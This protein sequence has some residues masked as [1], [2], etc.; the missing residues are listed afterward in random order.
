MISQEQNE[1]MTRVGPGT[2]AGNLLRNY[3]QPIALVD[4]LQGPRPV[5]ARTILGESFV[6]FKDDKGKYG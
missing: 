3:W 4:E 6:L 5:L 2:P 1:L